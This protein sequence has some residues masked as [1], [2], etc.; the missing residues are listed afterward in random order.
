MA[1]H[2]QERYVDE[3]SGAVRSGGNAKITGGKTNFAGYIAV[4]FFLPLPTSAACMSGVDYFAISAACLRR[5]CE[6][7]C[8]ADRTRRAGRLTSGI[9]YSTHRSGTRTVE[10][11]T[12]RDGAA[13]N[14]LSPL[15]SASRQRRCERGHAHRSTARRVSVYAVRFSP[16]RPGE[17]CSLRQASGAVLAR[18]FRRDG[19]AFRANRSRRLRARR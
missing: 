18:R 17:K 16:R 15:T 1:S 3:R 8:R 5:R 7:S 2:C 9:D 13:K 10:C 6:T 12:E 14:G 4:P 11:G 19:S